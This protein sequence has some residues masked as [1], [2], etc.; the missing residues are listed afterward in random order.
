M[1]RRWVEY[2]KGV[3]HVSVEGQPVPPFDSDEWVVIPW[4]PYGFQHYA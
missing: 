3:P 4:N 1:R 2:Y